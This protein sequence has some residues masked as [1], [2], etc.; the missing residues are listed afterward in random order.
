MKDLSTLLAK[1]EKRQTIVKECCDL[2][3]TEVKTKG[4]I[5]K[6]VYR[7]VKAIKPGTIPNAVDGLLDDFVVELQTFYASFQDEGG[8]GTL[9]SYYGARD[10][11][12]AEKLLTVTD[13]RAAGSRHTTMVK[14][15]HKLRPKGKDHVAAAVPKI[16]AL[17][18]RHIV[19]L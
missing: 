6:G 7:M 9:A 4:L 5:V 17:L 15:Y 14:G 19:D 2:I 13:S 16:G 12:V 3:D 11:E 10:R 18:D 1:P 8:K